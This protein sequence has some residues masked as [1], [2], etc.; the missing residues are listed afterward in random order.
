[1]NDDEIE[2]G[3]EILEQVGESTHLVLDAKH[4]TLSDE[5]QTKLLN[6]RGNTRAEA[7]GRSYHFR[8]MLRENGY[9][10]DCEYIG[11][12]DEQP[13]WSSEPRHE[14]KLYINHKK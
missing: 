12:A 11:L 10:A 2:S 1:M 7:L 9:P 13:D 6:L 3:K 4:G 14:I 8:D 5:K